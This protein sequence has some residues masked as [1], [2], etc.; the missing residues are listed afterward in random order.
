MDLGGNIKLPG[1]GEVPKKTALIIGG[2]GTLILAVLIYRSRKAKTAATAGAINPATGYAY[3][4]PEDLAALAAQGSSLPANGGGAGSVSPGGTIPG[5][6]FRTNAEWS[7][8][9]LAYM[10]SSGTVQDI[11]A[12]QIALG[13]YLNGEPAGAYQSLIEQA[14]AVEGLPPVAGVNGYPPSINTTAA[15]VPDQTPTYTYVTVQEGNHV[16]WFLHPGFTLDDLR[17]LNPGIHIAYANKNGYIS[18]TNPDRGDSIPV[19][20][21]GTS[22]Q[23]KVPVQ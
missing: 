7:Q 9:V 10:Q 23:I 13:L 18:A 6:G 20:N 1:I 15:P 5:I 16:D 12:V 21:V 8:A 14:I 11:G 4:T 2:G 3:G 17:T 22:A 19:F